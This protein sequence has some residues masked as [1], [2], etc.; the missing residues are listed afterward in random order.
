MKQGLRSG[1]FR[2]W[3]NS[4]KVDS[5]IPRQSQSA[6][7]EDFISHLPRRCHTLFMQWWASEISLFYRLPRKGTCIHQMQQPLLSSYT[8]RTATWTRTQTKWAVRFADKCLIRIGHVVNRWVDLRLASL[9]DLTNTWKLMPYK[10]PLKL[11]PVLFL[12]PVKSW[13]KGYTNSDTAGLGSDISQNKLIHG[14]L[15]SLSFKQL[16]LALRKMS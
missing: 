10:L 3:K 8:T 13:K 4:F 14:F 9:Q 1:C 6:L 2:E 7:D 16:V 5:H 12:I 11:K 15:L